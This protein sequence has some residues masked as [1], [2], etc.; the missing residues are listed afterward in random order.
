[1]DTDI[2][3]FFQGGEQSSGKPE[4]TYVRRS[5]ILLMYDGST[6]PFG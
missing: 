5:L 3:L 6:V 2:Q 1:M 4:I